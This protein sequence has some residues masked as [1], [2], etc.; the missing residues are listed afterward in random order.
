MITLAH[1]KVVLKKNVRV[2]L[3]SRFDHEGFL[4]FYGITF[5]ECH[6]A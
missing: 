2:H 3:P 5:K 4:G 1:D 6:E